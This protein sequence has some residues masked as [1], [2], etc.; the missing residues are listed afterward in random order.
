MHS[1][2]KDGMDLTGLGIENP[3][4]NTHKF[5][6]IQCFHGVDACLRGHDNNGLVCKIAITGC[7]GKR[8]LPIRKLHLE[9]SAS[10]FGYLSKG[11]RRRET[12]PFNSRPSNG[13]KVG[14]A[15]A[16]DGDLHCKR[17]TCLVRPSMQSGRLL[18]IRTDKGTGEAILRRGDMWSHRRKILFGLVKAVS[19]D[20]C[21]L[22]THGCFVFRQG[23]YINSISLAREQAN[24]IGLSR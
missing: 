14:D 18:C 20:R 4:A 8:L 22:R 15:I 23:I 13:K 6:C 5:E 24:L 21:D 19:G 3:K 17:K 16:V 2:R 7:L 9:C 12:L 1:G 10:R 11:Q